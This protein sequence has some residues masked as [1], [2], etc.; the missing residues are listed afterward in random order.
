MD[1]EE[2]SVSTD[3]N[4]AHELVSARHTELCRCERIPREE[5]VCSGELQRSATDSVTAATTIKRLEGELIATRKMLR[6][7][8]DI[9]IDERI[10]AAKLE[11]SPLLPE[12]SL[13]LSLSLFFQFLCCHWSLLSTPAAHFTPTRLNRSSALPHLASRCCETVFLWEAISLIAWCVALQL[14]AARTGANGKQWRCLQQKVKIVEHCLWPCLGCLELFIPHFYLLPVCTTS[15]PLNL[16][17]LRCAHVRREEN[18]SFVPVW[19]YMCICTS[20]CVMI[21][22]CLPFFHWLATCAGAQLCDQRSQACRSLE[23]K[24]PVVCFKSLQRHN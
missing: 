7:A 10:L 12:P 24:L 3:V 17:R 15:T 4:L 23:D 20:S 8:E 21:A 2:S 11:R 14:P 6:A 19:L 5:S 16:Q 18:K 1:S 9:I 22:V 13:L